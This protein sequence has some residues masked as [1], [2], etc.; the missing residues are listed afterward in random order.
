MNRL[1]VIT[2][3]KDSIETTLRTI[4]S[5]MNQH[6]DIEFKY[7]V[8]NDFSTRE[9]TLQL[10]N[11]SKKYGFNLINLADITAHPS[12]NYR[13]ILQLAQQ[14]ALKDN[15]HLLI[16]ES[17]VIVANNTIEQLN[18]I[19]Q[20]TENPGMLASV[21]VDAEENINFPYLYAKEFKYGQIKTNKRL[22][23]CCTLLTN[24]L[25]SAYDFQEL[26][27]TK[28]WYDIFVSHK[29]IALGF[30]NYLLTNLPVL[31][32]PHSSRPWKLLKYSHPI[33]Y[34]LRKIFIHNPD[35]F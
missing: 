23:F 18:K 29:S 9:T 8:Y 2:P 32:L 35:K 10:Q 3:V 5:V 27:S 4:E 24:K 22:S 13:M 16:V 14:E 12:P 34:Y 19:A 7:S 11:T 17:D 6:S 15:A 28:S 1:H 26:D 30:D 20:N 31:H 21:T 25:L 33:K